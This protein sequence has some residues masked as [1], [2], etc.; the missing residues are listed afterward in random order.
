MSQQD[1][2]NLLNLTAI[3]KRIYAALVRKAAML[4]VS[5]LVNRIR[6]VANM[7]GVEPA[8]YHLSSYLDAL[9]LKMTPEDFSDFLAGF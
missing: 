4:P 8:D 1:F 2:F 3:Q 9:C 7:E 5:E 6:A